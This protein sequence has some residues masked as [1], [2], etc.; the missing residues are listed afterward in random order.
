MSQGVFS[1]ETSFVIQLLK[2]SFKYWL[3]GISFWALKIISII[4]ICIEDESK[5]FLFVQEMIR[6]PDHAFANG[7]ALKLVLYGKKRF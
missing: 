1:I 5:S 4:W 2:K 6:K 7:H 3:V